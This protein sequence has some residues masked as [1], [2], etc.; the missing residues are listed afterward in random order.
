V[1]FPSAPTGIVYPGDPGISRTLAPPGNRDFA[2][3]I[4]VAYSPHVRQDSVLGKIVGEPGKTSI[5]ASFG[6]FYAAIQGETLGLISD[7]AP[8]GFTYTSPA[9]PLFSTPFVDAATGNVEGQRFPAQLA[10][11]NASASNP[12]PNIDFSQ[13]EPISATPGY[14]PTNLIGFLTPSH[15]C[16][17][18]SGRLETIPC[19]K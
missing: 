6:I 14:K 3:R 12:D 13:F 5:R 7:N 11:S 19:S 2:P 1:V 10:P 8:Y 18:C 16:C 4:G 15:M 17:L 9:P